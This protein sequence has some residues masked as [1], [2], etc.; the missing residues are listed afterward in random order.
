MDYVAGQFLTLVFAHHGREERRSYS[1]SS[2]GAEPPAI[3]IK[4]VDNGA[5]SRLLT[6]RAQVGDILYTTGPAGRFTL[7]A[8]LPPTVYFFAAGIGIT[9]VI[10]LIKELLLTHPASSAVLVYSNS[11]AE[12]TVFASELHALAQQ[13]ATRFQIVYLFSNARDLT[14]ARLHKQLVPQLLRETSAVPPQQ[15]LYYLCGPFSYMRMVTYALEEAGIDAENIRKENFNTNDRAVPH[16]MPPDTVTRQVVLHM[17]KKEWR[18][19][20]QYPESILAAARKAGAP[21]Q[22]SCEVGRCGSC[23]AICTHGKIWHSYNEVLT[24]NELKQG[25]VLMC[26]AHPNGEDVELIA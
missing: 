18:F 12:Q 4:R 8:D 7:S 1:F 26:T 6:D 22:F 2:A 10:S 9:P 17:H 11:S 15:H 25:S 3:T 14:R 5:Y 16:I 19:G 23:A 20:V 13:Y 21:V 24:D